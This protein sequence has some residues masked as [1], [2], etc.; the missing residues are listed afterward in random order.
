MIKKIKSLFYHKTEL[1]K[2]IEK[3]INLFKHDINNVLYIKAHTSTL[4][5]TN[6]KENTLFLIYL[7]L[8]FNKIKKN[9]YYIN[10]YHPIPIYEKSLNLVIEQMN[11]E[12][13]YHNINHIYDVIE[14]ICIL[15]IM[16]YFV[17]TTR[18]SSWKLDS[19]NISVI[20][21][22][23]A[24]LFHDVYYSHTDSYMN[25]NISCFIFQQFI[26]QYKNDEL[27]KELGLSIKK[28][29][30]IYIYSSISDINSHIMYTTMHCINGT[31]INDNTFYIENNLPNDVE[32]IVSDA[33]ILSNFISKDLLLENTS[34]IIKESNLVP[35][36]ELTETII[37]EKSLE[38]LKNKNV[39][40]LQS[41]IGSDIIAACRD[42]I[43]L[44]IEEELKN[45]SSLCL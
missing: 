44:E 20:C 30:S 21:S 13:N 35:E 28:I 22:I 17:N 24:G 27:V 45:G 12:N 33:D 11:N 9:S 32:T 39:F 36:Y 14:N 38:F 31:N 18:D 3:Y 42:N 2:V 4:Y 40:K 23:F 41:Y 26:S 37:Y 25:E 34:N 8:N 6:R 7:L 29:F 43:I 10:N 19:N 15:W 16:D 5:S 1:E